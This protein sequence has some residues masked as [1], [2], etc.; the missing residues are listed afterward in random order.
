MKKVIIVFHE[1]V[2]FGHDCFETEV[3]TDIEDA[4]AYK[5]N[6][7]I[8]ILSNAPIIPEGEYVIEDTG[9][10]FDLYPDGRYDQKHESIWINER[11]LHIKGDNAIKK[12]TVKDAINEAKNSGYR[13]VWLVNDSRISLLA[14]LYIKNGEKWMN[15]TIAPF[16]IK[17]YENENVLKQMQHPYQKDTWMIFVEYSKVLQENAR[18][19]CLAYLTLPMSKDRGFLVQPSQLGIPK[20]YTM[21]PSVSSRVPHG[22]L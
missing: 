20:S 5:A 3:F 10:N 14:E 13:R 17:E 11:P 1:S 4:K 12:N 6:L 16:V 8:K 22:T 18:N 21:S 19:K 7:E 9:N 15:S 2:G